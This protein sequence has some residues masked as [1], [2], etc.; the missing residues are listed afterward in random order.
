[1]WYHAVNIVFDFIMWMIVDPMGHTALLMLCI[2]DLLL[3]IGC[4]LVVIGVEMSW[5]KA[6]DP[7]TPGH[8]GAAPK[9][10]TKAPH[11]PSYASVD[12][13]LDK[14]GTIVEPEVREKISKY[15]KIMKLREWVRLILSSE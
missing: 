13:M 10:K 15:F 1:M 2:F 12:D 9:A 4:L 14:P 7:A 11:D 6:G 5:R 8:S 3:A